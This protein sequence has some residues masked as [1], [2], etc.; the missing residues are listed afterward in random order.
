MLGAHAYNLKIFTASLD[1][2][3]T[4]DLWKGGLQLSIGDPL[5]GCQ[6]GCM[7]PVRS[8]FLLLSAEL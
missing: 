7:R 8:F 5:H 1:T 3:D 6:R 4:M 2:S